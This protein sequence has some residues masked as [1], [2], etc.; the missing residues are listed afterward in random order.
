VQ[1]RVLERESGAL[2]VADD[3]SHHAIGISATGANV[4]R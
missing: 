1:P 3:I 4:T 2:V